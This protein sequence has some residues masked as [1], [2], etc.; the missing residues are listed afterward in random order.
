MTVLPGGQGRGGGGSPCLPSY[1]TLGLRL[2]RDMRRERESVKRGEDRG[3][4]RSCRRVDALL[5]GTGG[6]NAPLISCHAFMCVNGAWQGHD[7]PAG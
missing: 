3:G 5:E 1:L 6:S 7:W 2:R 4:G